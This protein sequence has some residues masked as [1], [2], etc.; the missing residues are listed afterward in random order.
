MQKWLADHPSDK[1]GKHR[2]ELSDFGLTADGVRR[3]VARGQQA[4][5]ERVGITAAQ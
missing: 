5:T 2:Y 4:D 1:H 3:R